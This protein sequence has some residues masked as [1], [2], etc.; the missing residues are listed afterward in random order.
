M[1]AKAADQ[2]RALPSCNAPDLFYQ[3]QH[4]RWMTAGDMEKLEKTVL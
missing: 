2:Q 3:C 1:Q 4:K